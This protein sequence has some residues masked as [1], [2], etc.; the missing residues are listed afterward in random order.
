M[1]GCTMETF[2]LELVFN[3]KTGEVK[4]LISHR[5]PSMSAMEIHGSIAD[6]SLRES[7]LSKVEEV[8]GPGMAALVRSGGI[9]MI[10]TDRQ[11]DPDE[12][13]QIQIENPA[14]KDGRTNENTGKRLIGD[15]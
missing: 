8:F 12:V 11:P 15:N 7:V 3:E 2:T 14:A 10:C 13:P 4:I 9:G 5:D 6:G 1:K